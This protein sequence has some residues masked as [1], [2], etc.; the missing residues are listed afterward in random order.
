MTLKTITAGVFTLALLTACSGQTQSAAENAAEN[1]KAK[2]GETAEKMTETVKPGVNI[3]DLP[4]G[5]YQS[6]SG[7]AYI[8]FSYNHQGYSKPIIRWGKFEA[9]VALTPEDPEKSGVGV[10][11]DV[12][13]VD[14]GVPVFDEHLVSADWFDAATYP[15]I[16]FQNT[17]VQQTSLGKGKLTGDLMI[18]GVTKPVTLD[19]TLNKIGNHFRSKKPMFGISATGSL[20]RSDFGI[21]KYA[22]MADD[23][24]LTI[25][26]EFIKEPHETDE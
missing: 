23:I 1:L 26:I 7:H 17:K 19:V 11:I 21:D 14:T 2:A 5:I 16:V 10:V 12:A 8:A 24:D 20:K 15:E 4:K 18:K 25:E 22:P 13:S 6:E 9:T 3:S